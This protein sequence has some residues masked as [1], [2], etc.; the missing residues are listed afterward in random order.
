MSGNLT[1]TYNW[2]GGGLTLSYPL[3]KELVLSVNYRLTLRSS[4]IPDD[5]YTQN[6]VGLCLTYQTP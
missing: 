2:Y 6:L 4:D 1:E 3:M 5:E